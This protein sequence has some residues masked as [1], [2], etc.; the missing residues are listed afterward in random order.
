MIKTLKEKYDELVFTSGAKGASLDNPLVIQVVD[1]ILAQAIEERAS[2]VHIEPTKDSL[3]VRYR[4]DGILYDM[5]TLRRDALPIIPRIKVM[6]ELDPDVGRTHTPQDGRF[7]L[8]AGTRD[9]DVRVSTFPTI[10]GEKIAVR[11]LDKE[12]TFRTLNELGLS[13][14]VQSKFET[15]IK[16]PNGMIFVTG[17]TNSGKT[18]TLYAVLSILNSPQLNIITLEDPV[19]YQL[20]G[21]NQGQVN[22]KVG[23]TFANGLRSVLRQDPNIILVGEIRDLETAEIAIRASLTGHLVFSTLHTNDAAGAV[24]RLVDMGIEPFLISSSLIGVLAQRLVRKICNGCKIDYAPPE[25]VL[26]EFAPPTPS[27][28]RGKWSPERKGEFYIMEPEKEVESKKEVPQSAP[29][30]RGKGCATC[31]QIGYRGRIGIFEL[32][33]MND[34]IRNLIV[35]KS[36]TDAINAAALRGGMRTLRDDGLDKA[37]AGVTTIEEVLRVTRES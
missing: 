12:V 36:A 37:R 16:R 31:R 18:S 13:E 32:M 4:I 5:L 9:V 2:D 8:R 30:Y 29:F 27:E 7:G 11:I 6:A 26:Q 22:P 15:L 35:A 3:R 33:E 24:T 21:V 20:K 10:L 28:K 23:L 17:P 25:A 34:E 14:A 1:L 19:E